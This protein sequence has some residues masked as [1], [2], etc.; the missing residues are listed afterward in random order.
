MKITQA[1]AWKKYLK[2][3]LFILVCLS[4]SPSSHATE[5]IW[6]DYAGLLKAYV[7]AGE[8][9]GV[10]V[11]L[12]H[13][14]AWEKDPRW[15]KLLITLS[16]FDLADLHSR[17]EKLSFWI[18]AYNIM[19]ISKVL[20]HW[21]IHSI[22]DAG[23]FFH[24]VWKQDA[25]IVAGKVR[26]LHEIEHQI[27]RPMDEPLMHMAIVCAS[28]SCPDLYR[29][30]YT[31]KKLQKQLHKQLIVFLKNPK[32]GLRMDADGLHISKIFDWFESDFASGDIAPW[33]AYYRKDIQPN[34]KIASYLPYDWQ[35]NAL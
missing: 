22:R 26:S 33:L 7:Q 28:V 3:L 19:A 16:T 6:A 25:G 2:Q 15:K 17:E 31:P 8:K 23:S 9:N 13:Y 11:N 27:L 10:R 14:A 12:V 21:P 30:P 32:K 34:T 1:F 5:T 18:N 20:E 29:E 24:S 4:Y 35:V